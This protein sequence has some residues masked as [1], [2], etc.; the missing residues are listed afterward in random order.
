MLHPLTTYRQLTRQTGN[1]GRWL[2]FR[3]PLFVALIFG[4]FISITVSGRLSAPL[5]LEGVV[6]W[7]FI[8][9]LQGL[10]V[11]CIVLAFP[12]GRISIPM[13]VDLFFMGYGPCLLWMLSIAGT[14]LFLPLKQIYLWPMQT[15]WIM[16][17][18]LLGVWLWSNA[19]SFAFFRGALSLTAIK[20][21]VALMLYTIV[22]WGIILSYLFALEILQLHR[23]RF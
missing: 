10:L 2:L 8:P 1:G 13:A 12:R 3:R 15:G 23:L 14:C 6:F 16:P 21:S 19:I 22:F 9:I 18:S 20:A 17:I 5:I 7:S 11:A 4:T